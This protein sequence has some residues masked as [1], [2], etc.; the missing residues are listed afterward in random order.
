[1][2]NRSFFYQNSEA[3]CR[4]DEIYLYIL[5]HGLHRIRDAAR[6]GDYRH[7]EVEAEH[8]HNLPAYIAEGEGAH[9]GYY[10]V[11]QRPHYLDSIDR[12]HQSNLYL[13]ETYE[14]LWDELE[15]L[16]PWEGSPW[17]TEWRKAKEEAQD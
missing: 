4:R 13:L 10:F 12:T 1:M 7:C 6:E 3:T 16:I 8:L 14:P 5:N 15:G 11:K 9:H 2:P 17:E